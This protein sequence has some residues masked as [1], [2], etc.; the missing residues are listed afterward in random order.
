MLVERKPENEIVDH[1]RYDMASY[2]IVLFKDG[3][4]HTTKKSKLKQ[5]LMESVN[6]VEAPQTVRSA[7][8]GACCGAVTGKRMRHSK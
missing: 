3:I 8:G 7:D 4:M 1:F 2:P 6:S 5:L